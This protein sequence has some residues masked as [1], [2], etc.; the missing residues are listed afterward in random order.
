VEQRAAE[1]ALKLEVLR[2]AAD[3]GFGALDRGEFKE[4][5][6]TDDLQVI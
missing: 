4:F 3:V 6:S 1:D 5:D 2:E